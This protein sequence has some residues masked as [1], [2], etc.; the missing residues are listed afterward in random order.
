MSELLEPRRCKSC[1]LCPKKSRR[2]GLAWTMMALLILQQ[3]FQSQ[4]EIQKN[5]PKKGS[6]NPGSTPLHRQPAPAADAERIANG[7]LCSSSS[8]NA[9]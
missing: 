4:V 3:M 7:R 9:L 6:V 5:K 2:H 8:S 1:Y